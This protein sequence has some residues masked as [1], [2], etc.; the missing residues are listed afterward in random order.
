LNVNQQIP[1]ISPV[2]T[3][4]LQTLNRDPRLRKVEN[5]KPSLL[6][7]E[8]VKQS[9]Q[10]NKDE[11]KFDKS[12]RDG[13]KHRDSKRKERSSSCSP[14]KKEP[15][16]KSHKKIDRK[17]RSPR[18]EKYH[19]KKDEKKIK[20]KPEVKKK[21]VPSNMKIPQA[22]I[23]ALNH[24]N[25]LQDDKYLIKDDSRSD[26]LDIDHHIEAVDTTVPEE[27]NVVTE[28][29]NDV[30]II[31]SAIITS[32][33]PKTDSP[34]EDSDSLKRLHMYMQ[35]MKKSPEPSTASSLEMKNDLDIRAVKPNQS[36]IKMSDQLYFIIKFNVGDLLLFLNKLD[37]FLRHNKMKT[38][39]PSI[40]SYYLAFSLYI[41]VLMSYYNIHIFCGCSSFI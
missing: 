14:S 15:S 4:L 40:K 9:V 11:K 3:Q 33:L 5:A 16:K 35:T 18:D 26:N 8:D 6:L 30:K 7:N 25:P 39:H 38:F 1:K 22:E 13:S 23:V 21:K 34:L 31:N 36:K 32:E 28:E 27:K 12:K 24:E 10:K 2:S 19:K 37:N 29:V 17:E 41:C 20:E